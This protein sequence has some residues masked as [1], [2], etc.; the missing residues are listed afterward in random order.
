MKLR[1]SHSAK[2]VYTSCSEK[3]RLQYI[4]KLRG[5]KITS[6]LFF[7]SAL[8]EAFSR[9]LIDKKQELT[10]KEKLLLPYTPEELF[11]QKMMVTN[12]PQKRGENV[13]IPF[14]THADY[15]AT[16]FEPELI[17]KDIVADIAS[18]EATLNWDK[19]AILKFMENCQAIKKEK[20]R[21]NEEDYKL[22]NYITWL[23][24][25]EKGY[26][27][28]DAYRTQIMPQINEVVSIQ[29]EIE[30]T[31]EYGDII[32]GFIDFEA[33]FVDNIGTIYVCDNKSSKDA[34]PADSVINSPQLSTY[35]EAVARTH[36]AYV[37]IRKKLFKKGAKIQT[38]VVKSIIPEKTL[39][40]T[41]DDFEN[42]VNNITAE[43]FEKN[44]NA[45]FSYGRMC[46][47]FAL[48]KHNNAEGLVSLKIETK[49][50]PEPEGDL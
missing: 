14:Y 17:N 30:I 32:P 26:L 39:Q 46:P 4:E 47:Y 25:V 19:T 11:Y 40:A 8:D 49:S 10:E 50:E 41:F 42:V 48:C 31:N 21:L 24:L 34:Y 27:M 35:C 44:F 20:K 9:L 28:V 23:T 16:D 13:T 29:K 3:Y 38:Q 45:C 37:V 22:S 2:D 33:D 7:G 5:P 6:S 36:A 15:Y 18:R 1:V 12:H 43:K